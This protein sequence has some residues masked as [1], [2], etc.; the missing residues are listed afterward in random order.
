MKPF[1]QRVAGAPITWGVDGS[2]GWGYLMDKDQ[3]LD[4]MVRIGL[5]ATELGP[6]GYLGDHPEDVVE[7][8]ETRGMS[9]VGG[10]IPALV[11]RDDRLAQT[12]EHFD[13]ASKT[14]AAGG[15]S[16][17]VIGPSGAYDGYD[18]T[19][20]LDDQDWKRF[21]ENLPRVQDVAHRHGLTPA[22]HP[23]WGMVIERRQHV[24]EL[25]ERSDVDLC[26]DTGH[27]ALAGADPIEIARMARGR[28]AHVHLKDVDEAK[29]E[30][31]RAGEVPFRQAV[32]DG[33]FKGLGEGIVDLGALVAELES[34]G[35]DGW[36]VLE[37]DLAL[38]GPPPPE[39]GPA[40]TARQSIDYLTRI[41]TDLGLATT[42]E[43][44][45]GT[46]D[47]SHKGG[48]QTEAENTKERT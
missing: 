32:I 33:L 29:A 48:P 35:F 27:L 26:L 6:D 42:G 11:Y 17:A 23:H 3:V 15:A 38:D 16:I 37:R 31:V 34:N 10:F 25:L 30:A 18:T 9:L 20:D 13:H 41:A 43:V 46:T 5:S 28:I 45:I 36:Y 8:L 40:Q 22:V 2:P 14:L 39:T 21:F 12:I 47:W 4:E 24:I 44:A 1:L 19:L 7:A